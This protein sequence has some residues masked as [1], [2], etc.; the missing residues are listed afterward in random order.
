M[1]GTTKNANNRF[2]TYHNL[3]EDNPAEGTVA[4][5]NLAEHSLAQD[6][7]AY[8]GVVEHVLLRCLR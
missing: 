5:D 1:T 6:N 8:P 2:I 4:E 3:A 7:L